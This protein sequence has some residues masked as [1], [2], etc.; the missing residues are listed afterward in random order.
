MS[1]TS[2]EINREVPHQWVMPVV[3]PFGRILPISCLDHDKIMVRLFSPCNTVDVCI[4]YGLIGRL[5]TLGLA[6]LLFRSLEIMHDHAPCE[7]IFQV[8]CDHA[9]LWDSCMNCQILKKWFVCIFGHAFICCA[10]LSFK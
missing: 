5:V 4:S 9:G 6:H 8:M 2:V 1:A 10:C 7:L 3:L